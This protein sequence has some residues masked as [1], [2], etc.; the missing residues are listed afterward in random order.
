MKKLLLL[1]FIGIQG[2][3]AQD[4]TYIQYSSSKV[5][6]FEQVKLVDAFEDAFG[7]DKEV[8]IRLKGGLKSFDNFIFST[9]KTWMISGEF[10]LFSQN[11]VKLDFY[12]KTRSAD[13]I[14]SYL[15]ANIEYRKYLKK[16]AASTNLSGNYVSLSKTF[17]FSDFESIY[18]NQFL[19]GFNFSYDQNLYSAGRSVTDLRLGQQFGSFM[20]MGIKLGVKR[21]KDSFLD[22]QGL[23]S[24][25]EKAKKY[26]PYLSSY[27]SISLGLD[28][29]REKAVKEFCSFLNCI[30][31]INHLFKVDFSGMFYVDQF[32]QNIQT[33]IAYEQKLG[34]LPVSIS[35]GMNIGAQR[36][37]VYNQ[38]GQI[39]VEREGWQNYT[40]P[41]YQDKRVSRENLTVVATAELRYYP[42]QKKQ[43]LAGKAQEGLHGLYLGAYVKRGLLDSRFN[44]EKFVNWVGNTKQISAWGPLVGFQKKVGSKHFMDVGTRFGDINAGNISIGDV[45]INPYFKFGY[46]L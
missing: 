8:K 27:S 9:Q 23:L 3:Y 45:M 29:P 25:T 38:V 41:K 4:S 12:Q 16:K 34:S 36:Y 26:I 46:G 44:S 14:P 7:Y 19:G 10:K 43:V 24:Y 1:F 11:S 39:E 21:A 33:E 42:L 20:D 13:F 6:T 28:F 17:N 37:E 40:V 2:L 18:G 22:E 30:E 32:K 31:K 35:L 5:N 15:I